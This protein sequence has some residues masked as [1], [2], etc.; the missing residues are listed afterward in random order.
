MDSKESPDGFK[1]E[2]AGHVSDLSSE[3][4][5]YPARLSLQASFKNVEIS[6]L[7]LEAQIDHRN[8]RIDDRLQLNISSYPVRDLDIVKTPSLRMGIEQ[9]LSSLNLE[10]LAQKDGVSVSLNSVL[11]KV[12]YRVETASEPLKKIYDDALAPLTSIQMDAT[13]QGKLPHIHW[14]YSST[15]S[16][17]LLSVLQQL[18]NQEY[19][20]FAARIKDKAYQRIVESKQ[21][22]ETALVSESDAVQQKITGEKANLK[23]LTAKY[24]AEKQKS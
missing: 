13:A 3:P 2:V 15:L 1:G 4:D 20:E 5:Q 24:L 19:A 18:L 11:D 23:E 10:Y 7:Q 22:L 16:E 17:R 8:D 6:N 21:A 14:T 12:I 9:A